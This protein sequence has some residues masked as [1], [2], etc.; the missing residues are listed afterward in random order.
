MNPHE[1]KKF[2]GLAP[3]VTA[4]KVCVGLMQ[5]TQDYTEANSSGLLVLGV[6]VDINNFGS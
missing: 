5:N 1:Y 6:N 3:E 4:L 2:V